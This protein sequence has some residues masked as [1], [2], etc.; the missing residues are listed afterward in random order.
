VS[1]YLCGHAA[2][3]KMKP[4]VEPWDRKDPAKK[5]H[6]MS[7]KE[8]G[9]AKAWAKAHGKPYPSLLANMQVLKK[10]H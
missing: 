6:H 2:L 1:A 9:K 3:W 4:P 8:V 10:K 5:H 7:K